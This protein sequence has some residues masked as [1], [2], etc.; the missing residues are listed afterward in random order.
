MSGYTNNAIFTRMKTAVLA[1]AST[2]DCTQTY[3]PTPTAFPTVFAREIGR[4]TPPT[5]A[6]LSNA[7]DISETTWEVHVLS[8]KKPGGKE[9]AYKLMTAVKSAFRLLY[10]VETFESPVDTSKDYYTLVARFRRIV[11]SGEE[12][13]T[14]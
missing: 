9:E 11:G 2:A 7:Q 1:V 3:N 12:L 5:T 6:T 10:F 4:F 14:N 8:N 13:P